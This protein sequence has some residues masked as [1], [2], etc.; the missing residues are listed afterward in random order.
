[1]TPPPPQGLAQKKGRVIPAFFVGVCLKAGAQGAKA[2]KKPAQG[3]PMKLVAL[4][5]MS[6]HPPSGE[7]KGEGR[8]LQLTRVNCRTHD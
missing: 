5:E 3:G 6:F 8:T 4:G 2:K 7:D 1:V